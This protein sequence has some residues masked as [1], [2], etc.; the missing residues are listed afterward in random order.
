[1]LKLKLILLIIIGFLASTRISIAENLQ[2]ITYYPAP[3]GA[4][5]RV[6]LLPQSSLPLPCSIGSLGVK[7]SDGKLLYCHNIAG[8]GTWGL[9]SNV[10]TL[11][12]TNL[13]PTT[14]DTN[15]LIFASIGTS[16]PGFKL[17]LE[18]DG[19]ILATGTFGSGIVTTYPSI[20]ADPTA[21]ANA[22]LI[23]YPRKA[24]FRAIWDRWGVTDDTQ[25]GAYSIGFGDTPT[26]TG[27]ATTISGLFN[28]ASGDYSAIA[29]GSNN[30]VS[31]N[32]STIAGGSGST[33]SGQYSVLS[34]INNLVFDDYAT[35]SG[36]IHN[37]S[38]GTGATITGGLGNQMS[39][40]SSYAT[41]AGGLNHRIPFSSNYG[42]ISGG[43][44]NY[45]DTA[46]Y[47][48]INGGY[49]NDING[50]YGYIGGG[51]YNNIH[52]YY[53]TINGGEYANNNFN[54]FGNPVFTPDHN[55]AVITGGRR[56]YTQNNYTAVLGGNINIAS[57]I[58]SITTGGAYNTVSGNR[59]VI[60]GGD[61]NTLAVDYSWT[62]GH[63]MNLTNTANRTFVW[64]YSDIP[65]TIGAADAFI[66]APGKNSG[67]SSVYNP[68]LGINETNPSGILSITL[69]AS[70][71]KDFLAITSTAVANAGDIFI[72]KNDGHVGIGKYN[73]N[74]YPLEFGAQA[75]GAYLTVGGVWTTPS[76]R[77]LKENI[78]PLNEQQAIETLRALKPVTYN[79]KIDPTE[80]HVG[81]IAEDVPEMIA[82]Q[83]RNSVDPMNITAILTAVL[84]EQKKIIA[85]QEEILT[86]LGTDIQNLKTELTGILH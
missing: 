19:G 42:T 34:G 15:P 5:D 63:Y 4:Y 79:Y 74:T 84:K 12:G 76:S 64:G 68:K 60:A 44:S 2:M 75:N 6:V 17:T 30:T 36:G 80:H 81:F 16:S 48:T 40:F 39:F 23:W 41:I 10:W 11:S 27:I 85:H 8:I 25:I 61:H 24:A 62:G 26:A 43:T 70:S 59:S 32:Y 54:E 21:P 55:W 18:N 37:Y 38:L 77:E 58:S 71:T 22:R 57:G 56:N 78:Q 9:L 46:D 29:G 45:L 51:K 1:M 86:T 69:P 53:N 33:A 3:Q 66:L 83:D 65:I 28:T 31:G 7:Q 67:G 35:V 50:F 82:A 47:S 73:P 20:A 72:V 52:G 13:Y 49:G 14:T